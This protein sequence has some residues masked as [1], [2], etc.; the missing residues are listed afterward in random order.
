MNRVPASLKR[1]EGLSPWKCRRAAVGVA[2]SAYEY[3]LKWSKTYTG[4]GSQPVLHHQAVGYS[5]PIEFKKSMEG[6]GALV[7]VDESRPAS[8]PL[9]AGT[10]KRKK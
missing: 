10:H 3:V 1:Q 4:G 2:R 5:M 6:V 9:T 7:S 8:S